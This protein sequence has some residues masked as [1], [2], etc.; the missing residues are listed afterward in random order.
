VTVFVMSD[1]ELP[2]RGRTYR[3]PEGPHSVVVRGRDIEHALQHVASREDCRSLAV[4]SLP[5]TVPDLSALA[6]RRLLLVDGDSGRLRDFAEIAL[7]ADIEVEWIRSARPPF[8]RLAAALLPVGAIVLAA[9]ASSRM[10]GSQ[11]LLLEFDGRPM[12]R[13]A[14]EAASDGGCQQVAVVYSASEVKAAVGDAAQLVYN[15]DART[16]MASSL[17]VGLRALRPEIEAAVVLLGD[18]PLVGSRTIAALLRAWRREGSR[19]AVAVSKKRGAADEVPPGRRV[20]PS[21]T[22]PVVLA[23]EMWDDLNKLEGDAGARQILDG[24]PELLD[25]V[26]APG[27]PDDI[28]TPEDYAKILSLFPRRKS[29]KRA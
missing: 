9:G 28:D 7:R 20:D 26:P 12:V 17:K 23:R 16:G 27:R 6:G 24:H 15:P 14:V 18:Q 21:W 8:E 25:T 10:S 22:P 29:R 2:I 4:I 1:L 3:E 13:H 5:T 11:K 19:P